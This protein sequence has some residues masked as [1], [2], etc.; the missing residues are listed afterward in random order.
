M[1]PCPHCQQA[2][3]SG[4]Q[5]L[6]SLWVHP[7]ACTACGEFA[8]LPVRNIIIALLVWTALTWVFIITALLMRNV[9]YLLGAIPAA[10]LAV[11][12]WILQAP[13]RRLDQG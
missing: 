1:H 4:L 3:Y 9:F 10:L 7:I 12:K 11:D 13:L 5:K 2:T 8:F 6:C